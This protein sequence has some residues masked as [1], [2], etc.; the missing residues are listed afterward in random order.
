MPAANAESRQPPLD[1]IAAAVSPGHPGVGVADRAAWPLTE[2][3][4]VPAN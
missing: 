2:K 1:L 4:V 3:L